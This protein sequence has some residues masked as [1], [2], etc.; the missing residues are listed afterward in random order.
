MYST[1]TA[2]ESTTRGV[3]HPLKDVFDYSERPGHTIHRVALSRTWMVICT[4]QDLAVLQIRNH[5]VDKAT[6]VR[7]PCAGWAPRGLAIQE[8]E[9]S[10]KIVLGQCRQGRMS[11]EGRM[12]LF[13][14]RQTIDDRPSICEPLVYN[15]DGGDHPKDVDFS[16]NGRLILCRTQLRNTVL[17]WKLPSHPSANER[18]ISISKSGYTP[19]RETRGLLV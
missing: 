12:L 16:Q 19:V 17:V 15:M 9:D 14:V 3:K 6:A 1:L 11:L 18:S 4:D 10:L 7:R 2:L 5:T 8:F 13:T